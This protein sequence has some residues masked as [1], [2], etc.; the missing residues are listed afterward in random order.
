M[1]RWYEV[2]ALFRFEEDT[3]DHDTICEI[4]VDTDG[5]VVSRIVLQKGN[6]C[7]LSMPDVGWNLKQLF[8]WL[9]CK[10]PGPARGRTLSICPANTLAGNFGAPRTSRSIWRYPSGGRS[11]SYGAPG[12]GGDT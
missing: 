7:L 2:R 9:D 1:N 6:Y 4:E 12:E 5:N 10:R 11:Q 8:N 3:N